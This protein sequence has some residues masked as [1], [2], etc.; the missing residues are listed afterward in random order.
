MR[1]RLEAMLPA[2]L[3]IRPYTAAHL[4]RPQFVVKL[5]FI[6]A[7]VQSAGGQ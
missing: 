7:G 6:Q 2:W 3:A 1:F 4:G 5:S